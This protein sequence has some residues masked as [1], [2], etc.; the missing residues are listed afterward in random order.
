MTCS[1][2][3]GNLPQSK[4]KALHRWVSDPSASGTT[5]DLFATSQRRS[6]SCPCSVRPALKENKSLIVF[7]MLEKYAIK[8]EV[9][10]EH[11]LINY[12]NR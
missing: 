10:D 6:S 1:W 9:V 12:L 5:L 7:V 4:Q 11:F 2:K 3:W 8:S